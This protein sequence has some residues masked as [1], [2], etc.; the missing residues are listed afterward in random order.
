VEHLQTIHF[1]ELLNCTN[2]NH[3]RESSCV[4][5]IVGFCSKT[6]F[7]GMICMNKLRKLVLFVRTNLDLFFQGSKFFYQLLVINFFY[8]CLNF[9]HH[10]PQKIVCYPKKCKCPINNGSMST[11]DSTIEKNSCPKTMV[12][13]K[14]FEVVTK[15]IS[16][17]AHKF[18]II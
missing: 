12:Q 6:S 10:L 16:I 13:L 9:F 3:R 5:C 2:S 11:I 18:S 14:S 1:I 15:K 4:L 7:I 8:H 17:I